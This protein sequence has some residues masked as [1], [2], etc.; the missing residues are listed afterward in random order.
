MA[1]D[2]YRSW[3]AAAQRCRTCPDV[4][5]HPQQHLHPSAV[6]TA[7]AVGAYRPQLGRRLVVTAAAAAVMMAGRLA[8]LQGAMPQF[9][10]QENPAACH[11]SV[12]VR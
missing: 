10:L 2:V 1:Y 6:S 8:V 4:R 3:P 11:D 7:A 9:S 5:W 12:Y